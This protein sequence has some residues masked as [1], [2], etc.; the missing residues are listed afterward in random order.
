M[1]KTVLMIRHAKSSWD[2]SGQPDFDRPLNE[3]GKL[4][5]PVMAKRMLD[6][7]IAIDAFI[8][9]TAK[10]AFSTAKRFAKVYKVA[11]EN[12]IPVPDLYHASTK[13]FY[14]AISETDNRYNHIAVFSHNPGITEFVNELT[15]TQID[16]MPTCA[17][18]AIKM[19]INNWNEFKSA[20]KEYWF[21]DYPK[22][23]R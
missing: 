9:S 16:E 23:A 17:I 13:D 12:I 6:K 20:T 19:T 22:L 4:D 2:M 1:E 7:G 21:F 18:F 3:R 5:A 10:R 11:E 8:S 14:K 15:N